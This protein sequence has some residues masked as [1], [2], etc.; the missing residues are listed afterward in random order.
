[1]RGLGD[2][3]SDGHSGD[4]MLN[5]NFF[6]EH[7][8]GRFFCGPIGWSVD[9]TMSGKYQEITCREILSCQQITL[10]INNSSYRFVEYHPTPIYFISLLMLTVYRVTRGVSA[11][12]CAGFQF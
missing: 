12:P 1:M 9:Q 5:K 8:K 7:S 4:S 10:T 11:Y 2:K 3:N 6:G